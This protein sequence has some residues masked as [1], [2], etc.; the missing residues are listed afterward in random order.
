MSE[1]VETTVGT[2]VAVVEVR[3][4]L[5]VKSTGEIVNLEDPHA[6]ADLLERIREFEH[7][8]RSVK[9]T[10]QDAIAYQGSIAGLTKITEGGLVMT[11][12]R[13][14]DIEWDLD[15]LAELRSLGLPDSTW[16]ELVETITS[17]KV[18][19]VVARRIAK[20][21]PE[22]AAVIERA[23]QRTTKPP[24]VAVADMT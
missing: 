21:N 7:E 8:A 11:I 6:C 5:V 15:V 10:L 17:Y 23:E 22:Y 12:T 14:V 9:R 18:R 16:N 24:T 1:A 20:A 4:E 3:G 13:P 19:T 2:E